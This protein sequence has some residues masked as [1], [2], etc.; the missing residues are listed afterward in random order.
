MSRL[1]EQDMQRWIAWK[2]ATEAVMAAVVAEIT[3]H[4]GLSAADFSVL[5]RVVETPA[6]P[7][8]SA[9]PVR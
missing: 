9:A 6:R 3:A 7:D 5:T 4:T 2:R 8:P 1:S